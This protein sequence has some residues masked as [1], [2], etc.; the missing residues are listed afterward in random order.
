[1]SLVLFLLCYNDHS[2]NIARHGYPELES[3][4][5]VVRLPRHKLM[6]NS[7]FLHYS[8]EFPKDG[9]VGFLS[10]KARDKLRPLPSLRF[11]TEKILS[12]AHAPPPDVLYFSRA[13]PNPSKTM[14]ENAC[15]CH[16]QFKELWVALLTQLGYSSEDALRGN[17]PFIAYNYWIASVSWAQRYRDFMLRVVDVLSSWGT[18]SKMGRILHSDSNYKGRLSTEEKIQIFGFPHYTYH[19]FLLERLPGFFFFKEGA[20]M[21]GYWD[22][23]TLLTRY[24]PEFHASSYLS[25]YSDLRQNGIRQPPAAARHF[26]DYGYAENRDGKVS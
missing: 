15:A 11:I 3:V 4:S 6:E 19:P 18:T 2:E 8:H 25:R 5:K 17:I 7:V 24:V 16:P 10:W 1:M 13:S 26:F 23:P 22:T 12:S 21:V 14:L 9:Y 20:N